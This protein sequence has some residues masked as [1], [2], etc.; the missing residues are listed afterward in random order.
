VQARH[1][2]QG[3]HVDTTARLLAMEEIRQTKA[4]YFRFIDTKDRDGL[5]SVFARDAVLDHTG[6]EMDEPVRGRDAIADFI[7]GVLVGVTTVHH[8][9]MAEVEIT[10]PTT[11]NAIFAME[12]KLWWNEGGPITTMHGYGHYHEEYVVEDGAWRISLNRLTRL[13]V[14]REL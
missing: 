10:S 7:T 2:D 1:A 8:G 11:A 3:D 14:D 12:D 5:A 6:A 13:R 4:R 9:H